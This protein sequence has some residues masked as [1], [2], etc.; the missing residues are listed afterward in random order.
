M[1][2]YYVLLL[3]DKT[4]FEVLKISINDKNIDINGKVWEEK[5]NFL[6]PV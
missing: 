5:I 1:S 3:K 6:T 4:I 2:P